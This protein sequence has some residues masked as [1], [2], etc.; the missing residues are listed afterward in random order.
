[1]CPLAV[2]TYLPVMLKDRFLALVSVSGFPQLIKIFSTLRSTLKGNSS[3]CP[4]QQLPLKLT[5]TPQ[6][7]RIEMSGQ[8]QQDT[9]GPSVWLTAD[10]GP[11]SSDW[12]EKRQKSLEMLPESLRRWLRPL[13][14]TERSLPSDK[15]SQKM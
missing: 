13:P 4:P 8:R 11:G 1:M 14:D 7:G 12:E 9:S 3:D 6:G 5:Q 2:A 10:S 15:P